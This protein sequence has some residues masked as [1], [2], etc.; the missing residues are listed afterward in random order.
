[1]KAL[2][3]SNILFLLNK[4]YLFIY[5]ELIITFASEQEAKHAGNIMSE[6]IKTQYRDFP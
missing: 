3:K 4:K 6:L 5:S 2:K 1:M